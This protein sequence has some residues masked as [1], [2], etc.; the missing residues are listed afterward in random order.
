VTIVLAIGASFLGLLVIVLGLAFASMH[1]RHKLAFHLKVEG[2]LSDELEHI[3]ALTQSHVTHHNRVMLIQDGDAFVSTC[4]AL[5]ES[6]ERSV[7][8][9]TFLWESGNMTRKFVDAFVKKAKAGV[10]VRVLLDAIGST[11]SR[12]EREELDAAGV[13]LCVLRPV[14]WRHLGF[15][16]NRT[17]RKILV[18]DGRT[19]VVGGHCVK[20]EWLGRARN[21]HEYRDVSVRLEGPV[22]AQVQSAFC[23]HWIEGTG[24]VPYGPQVFPPLGPAGHSSACA[25]HTNPSGGVS[26]TKLLHHLALHRAQKRVWIQSPYFVPDDQAREALIKAA[27]RGVDVRILT[28][29]IDVTDNKLVA[30]AGHYRLAPF[31]RAGVKVYHYRRTLSHQK[32]WTI[33]GELALIGSTN[34]DER[35]FHLDDQITIAIADTELVDEID[36]IMLADLAQADLIEETEWKRRSPVSKVGDALAYLLRENL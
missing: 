2:D 29:R 5:I 19:A 16:N 1:R 4:I 32:V 27:E 36:R 22:V 11:I 31:L 35:S 12:E 18:V 8:F 24:R 17:H 26:S 30:H 9:E 34:F 20:D 10:T 23:G 15:L 7:H 28:P 25:I 3:A 6:A 13:R 21:P 14:G 33:D